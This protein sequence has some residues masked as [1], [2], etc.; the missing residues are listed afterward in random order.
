MIHLL[1]PN[2]S[3]RTFCGEPNAD[4]NACFYCPKCD[5]MALDQA[6]LDLEL[7]C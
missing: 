5:W 6:M 4:P 1:N 7:N 3:G 2:E